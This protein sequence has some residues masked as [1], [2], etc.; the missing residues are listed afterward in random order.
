MIQSFLR[1]LPSQPHT[2][3]PSTGYYHEADDNCEECTGW[4]LVLPASLLSVGG[5]GA[6][7]ALYRLAKKKLDEASHFHQSSLSLVYINYLQVFNLIASFPGFELPDL[8]SVSFDL[9]GNLFQLDLALG[10]SYGAE[11]AGAT[12]D[13][14]ITWLARVL[15]PLGVLALLLLL[16]R[17]T[18]LDF[19]RMVRTHRVS[20][21]S[22]RYRPT[23]SRN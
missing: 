11:C 6:V 4:E 22:P 15:G 1:L 10:L 12:T 8:F 5:A 17:F 14:F 3:S 20:R 7:V 18:R 16:G 21:T 19:N 23:L 13:Y 2:S 9:L